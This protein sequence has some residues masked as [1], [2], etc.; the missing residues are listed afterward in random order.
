MPITQILLTA[1][2]GGPVG[3]NAYANY[4]VTPAEGGSTD[5]TV[6][7]QNWDGSRIWWSVVGKGSPAADP[8]TDMTGTLSGF[9][10][11]GSGT[12]SS[13]VTTINFTTGS[14]EGTEYWGV[15]LGTTEGASD[16]W[17]G[18][19]WE[20]T[21]PLFYNSWTIEWFQKSNSSQPSSFPRVFGVAT[22]PSQSI[23]FS[24]EG[25]YY[26]WIA[27]SGL[28]T[29]A[30][31]AHN[32]WQHWAMVS[33]GSTFSMYRNGSR[34]ATTG[35][36]SLGRIL[37]IQNDF[38]V[39]IDS[40]PTNGYKGLLTNFRVVKGQAMYDPTQTTITTP[41]V[42]LVSN[43]NTELLLKAMD[44]L[45]LDADSSSRSRPAVGTSGIQFSADTPFTA[46]GPYTQFT[47]VAS[48]SIVDFGNS[49]YNADLI[50]VKAGW[51]VTDGV[52]TGTVT[53]DASLMGPDYIRISVSLESEPGRTWTF[54]QPALGGSIEFYP[55]SNYGMIRY[56]YGSEW[57]LDI[58]S[59]TYTLTLDDNNVNEGSLFGVQVTGTGITDGNYY[60]T[61][62][63]SG[64][65]GT[66][67]G[68]FPIGSNL[69]SFE[70]PVTADATTEGAETFTVQIRSGS[71]AGPILATSDPVTI[72]DTSLTKLQ[73][74]SGTAL[75]FNGTDNRHVIVAD[76]LSNWNLGDN[77]TIEWWHKIPVGVDGFLS[78]LCQDANV[79]TY[80]G[81]DVFV[82]AGSICMFNGNLNFSEAAATRG[83]WNHIAIQKNVAT[84]II[85]AY[86]NGVSQSVSGSHPGTIA[87]SSPLNVVI[88]SR[89]ADGGATFYNQFFNGQLANIRISN[90]A[91]YS[92][93]FTPPTTVVTDAG[94]LL[95]LDGSTGGGGML[96]DESSRHTLTNNGATVDT[97]S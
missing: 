37:N 12:L 63:N 36:S 56:N 66:A 90:S 18:N 71:I 78:V 21:E 81:I 10:D 33:D 91:R 22:Y 57:A 42:P 29:S 16:I 61:V 2:A 59:P 77:W 50:N 25:T 84:G 1:G 47:N 67:S 9:W 44:A 49:N 95:G 55:S 46:N 69:G 30:S 94:T 39:G 80:S 6:Y 89:T 13:V 19:T 70:F 4:G 48:G 28:V 62:T 88:G 45:G 58:P 8:N 74:T 5:I 35:R 60:W 53:S 54:T 34:V 40:S 27:G 24:L 38:Y 15:N 17:N 87:P 26:G 68:V 65:F 72:N 31:I 85:S 75:G 93:T 86:I 76:N 64:D 52:S 32:T 3:P 79:P 11:P 73:L 97:I 51:T 7:V 82:N 14:V 43:S 83:E 92:T 41:V 23:G 96:T 20:I